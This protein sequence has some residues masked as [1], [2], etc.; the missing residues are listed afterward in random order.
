MS[1]RAEICGKEYTFADEI[2]CDVMIKK[3][4]AGENYYVELYNELNELFPI[5]MKDNEYYTPG[6]SLRSCR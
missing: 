4:E 5:V 2:F 1:Y 6:G 3:Y